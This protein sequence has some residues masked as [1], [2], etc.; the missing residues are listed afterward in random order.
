MVTTINKNGGVYTK[1]K[2][3]SPE[4]QYEIKQFYNGLSSNHSEDEKIRITKKRLNYHRETIKKYAISDEILK[5]G[6]KKGNGT[7]TNNR[8]VSLLEIIFTSISTIYLHEVKIL[9]KQLIGLD[10][11]ISQIS[12]IKTNILS[13]NYKK[14]TK[15][16]MYKK[17]PRVIN[18]RKLYCKEVENIPNEVLYF[19]DESNFNYDNI[20]R[21]Y[22][23]SIKGQ[24]A[25]TY[26]QRNISERYSLI[27]C[28]SMYGICYYEL[29]ETSSGAIDSEKF[30]EFMGR[31]REYVINTHVIVLD[32]ARI[33]HTKEVKQ[34]LTNKN[35]K[36]L[37]Q[38]PYS[39]EFNPCEYVFSIIKNRMKNY[40]YSMINIRTIVDEVINGLKKDY[41]TNI[42]NHCKKQMKREIE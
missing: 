18:L 5:P 3:L 4:K 30:K 25:N 14:V 19:L 27:L 15:M 40:E 39:P 33:H 41:F 10:I 31:L 35:Y 24:R 22:G 20:V 2:N 34:Y 37:F 23:H 17:E 28:C 32:N 8:V 21:N 36:Y 26:T 6:R 42:V 16:A 9:V 11:S 38:S 12:K 13:M 7:T 1:G 29:V